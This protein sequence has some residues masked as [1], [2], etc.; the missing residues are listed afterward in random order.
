MTLFKLKGYLRRYRREYI[1]GIGAL[2]LTV[3]F[4]VAVPWF[5]KYPI[6][7]LKQEGATRSF[8]LHILFFLFVALVSAFFRFFMRRI[9]I[10]IS[11]KIECDFRNDFFAHLQKLSLSFYH[12]YRT[13]DI[14]ARATN[15]INA[16]RNVLGPGI[17]YSLYTFFYTL[18]ALVMMLKINVRLTLLALI[19]FPI[20]AIGVN[21]LVKHLY[22]F[23]S[24]VQGLFSDIT[25]LVEED[26]SGIRVIKAYRQENYEIKKFEGLNKEYLQN[27]LKLSLFRGSM[28]AGITL[29]AGMGLAIVL[30]FGGRDVILQK[31]TLGEF[32]SFNT[33]LTTL[34]WPMIAIGWVINLFQMGAASYDR[35]QKIMQE[36][37]EIGDTERTDF[38][39][40]ELSGDLEFRRVYFSY[41]G[42]DADFVLRDLN[43]RIAE[44]MLVAVVGATGAGKTTLVHL[45]A[46]LY[47]PQ[48]G[49]ILIGGREIREIPLQVLRKT[50]GM[51]PQEDFLFSETVSENIAFNSNGEYDAQEIRK[52]AETVDIAREIEGF[53]DR[54]DTLLGERGINLSG[55]QKQ[56]IAIARAALTRPKILILDDALSAVDTVTEKNILNN[57]KRD[58]R[59]STRIIVTHRVTSL[60]DADLILV[61]ERGRLV[62]QGKHEELLALNGVYAELYRKQLIEEELEQIE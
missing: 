24:K 18:F 53:A 40:R 59:A 44:G 13:G 12:R 14:M 45:M 36:E 16:V 35:I 29:F 22:R 42:E 52:I 61:L 26:V 21:R 54:Y 4:G 20:V 57:L 39:I 37:P 9:L 50:I 38:S 17:M 1:L 49:E 41:S 5:L 62:E 32:V 56:R 55:G 46:R 51:V 31:I 48:R 28:F 25:S 10:G 15:D 30:Y 58:F 8:Y 2:L 19:P 47:E 7:I 3:I 43:F 34:I 33:Y 6:D 11:R 60:I 23:S 27:N